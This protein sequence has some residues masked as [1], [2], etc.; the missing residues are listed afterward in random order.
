MAPVA[1]LLGID[2]LPPTCDIVVVV[3]RIAG[4]RAGERARPFDDAWR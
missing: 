2:I 1:A 4:P 3:R